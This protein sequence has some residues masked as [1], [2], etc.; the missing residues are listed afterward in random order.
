MNPYELNQM[1]D[2]LAPTPEQERAGLDR[3]LHGERTVLFMKKERSLKNLRKL[4]AAGIAAALLATSVGAAAIA[5]NQGWVHFFTSEEEIR[6]AANAGAAEGSVANYGVYSGAG[7]TELQSVSEWVNT[8]MESTSGD[9]V[10]IAEVQ[11]KPEDGWTRMRAEQFVYLGGEQV[12]DYNYQGDSLSKLS[13]LWDAGWDLTWLEE[14]YTA[15]PGANL[16]TLRTRVGEDDPFYV[17]IVGEY[18]GQDGRIFNLKYCY[19]KGSQP[20]DSY[21]L[22]NGSYEYYALGGGLTA[23]INTADSNDGVPQFWVSLDIGEVSCHITGERMTLEDVHELLD[24]LDLPA[25]A[26]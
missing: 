23:S 4:A 20:T 13:G 6:Q 14:N 17:S 9:V 7:Y 1:F 26:G 11:G 10:L 25:L 24:S 2:R 16:V 12:Q 21:R 15:R 18:Q 5:Q 3:L 8:I 19:D 22:T